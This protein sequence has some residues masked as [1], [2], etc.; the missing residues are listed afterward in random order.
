[1]R[2]HD[3]CVALFVKFDN[4]GAEMFATMSEFDIGD[5]I[6]VKGTLFKTRTEQ[7]SIRVAE[8]TFLS[9]SLLNLPEKWHGLKDVEMRYRQ[10][11]LDIISNEEVKKIYLG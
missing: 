10:R 5:I 9:K 4:V 1:M 11:Y 7:D 3:N 2:H 6:G 8:V